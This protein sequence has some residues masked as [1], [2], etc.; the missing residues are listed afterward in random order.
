MNDR[1]R[2]A[3]Y[4]PDIAGNTGTILRFAACLGLGV[5]IIEPAGFPL[6]DRALK[7]AGMD[8]LEMADLT[9]HV[10]WN[11][12]AQWRAGDARRLVLL[13]T[14]A[15]AAYTDFA[16]ADGDILLFGRESAGVP[17]PVH[18]AADA[19]LTIPMRPGARS[20]NVALSVAMVA[21]EAIRQ[22]A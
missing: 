17:D 21:G 15:A 4:Q 5:D 1:L 18:D 7:R 3:L 20:I 10:D 12:F 19:R 6:S 16:F 2:I 13:T 8:Y 9:R 14:K 22:L 11:A